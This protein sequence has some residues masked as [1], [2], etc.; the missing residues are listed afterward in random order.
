MTDGASG[1]ATAFKLLSSPQVNAAV[2]KLR[3]DAEFLQKLRTILARLQEDPWHFGERFF[4]FREMNLMV[5][6]GI[7]APYLVDFAIHREQP[8]VFLRSIKVLSTI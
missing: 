2:K 3:F 6:H 4:P 8:W 1:H 7:I 5:C